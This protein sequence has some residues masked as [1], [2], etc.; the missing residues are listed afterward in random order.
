MEKFAMVWLSV[1]SAMFVGVLLSVSVPVGLLALAG[2]VVV[3]FGLRWIR[4][5]R[6]Q[7]RRVF[8]TDEEEE[9]EGG[10]VPDEPS[11]HAG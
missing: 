6:Q 7:F 2:I 1:I 11:H 3:W 5:E 9:P 10:D 8:H 4:R